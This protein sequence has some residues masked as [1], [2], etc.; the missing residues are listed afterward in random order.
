MSDLRDRAQAFLERPIPDEIQ[1]VPNSIAELF[2]RN[3][4]SGGEFDDEFLGLGDLAA[5]IMDNEVSTHKT[6]EAKA[7]FQECKELLE[8]IL[9]EID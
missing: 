9:D 8:A 6:P 1:Y 2:I 3:Y 4:V 5:E 7:F